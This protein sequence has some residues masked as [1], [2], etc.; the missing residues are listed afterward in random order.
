MTNHKWIKEHID[1]PKALS[2]MFCELSDCDTCPVKDSCFLPVHN[3]FYY[4]LREQREVS[5]NATECEPE[6]EKSEQGGYERF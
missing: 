5:R 6:P 1:D 4:W 2:H 3:G